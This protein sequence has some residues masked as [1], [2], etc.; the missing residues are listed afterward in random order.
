MNQPSD[1]KLSLAEFVPLLA[2]MV[3]LVALSIDAMLPVLPHIGSDLKVGTENDQQLVVSALLL[4]LGFGQLLFGPLSDSLG[5]K[6]TIYLGYVAFVLGCVLSIIATNFEVMLIGRVLQGIGAASPRIVSIAVVRDQYEGREMARIM[7]F[8][9]GVFI[10]V[11]ALAPAV[12]QVIVM[13]THWRGIFVVFLLLACITWTWFALRQPE[14]LPRSAR[15]GFSLSIVWA[16]V[17]EACS[18]RQTLGYTIVA[19]LIFA[20]FIAYLSSAQQIFSGIYGVTTTFPLYFAALAISMGVSTIAN[21]MLVERLGMRFLSGYALAMVT[22]ISIG[23]F[24]H[25]SLV[26]GTPGFW[27]TMAYFAVIFFLFGFLF[28]NLNALAMVPLGHIAGVGAA[29]VGSIS[30]LISVP[31]GATLGLMYNGTV[32]PLVGGFALF[33]LLAALLMIWIERGRAATSGAT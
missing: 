31:F 33:G 23:F 20:A 32:L 25:A 21:A 3:S 7:S 1:P 13:L 29:V 12:G 6:R 16:G 24:V 10:I 17:K 14:T 11:P 9:M 18:Y 4:G 28:G 8:I 5:R 22:V 15:V 27:A 2:L 30:T 26:G 19:G